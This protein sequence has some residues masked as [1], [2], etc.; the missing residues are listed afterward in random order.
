MTTTQPILRLVVAYAQNRCI[1]KDN[2]LPWH[3]PKDL[4]HFKALTLGHPIIMGRHTWESI[5]RPLPGRLNIVISRN[6]DFE[7]PGA[8]VCHS[9]AQALQHTA[10]QP[11]VCVIGGAQIYQQA[12][13]MAHEIYAT[14]VKQVVAGDAFFPALDQQWQETKRQPQPTE[15]G[16]A[17]DFVRYE[18]RGNRH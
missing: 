15:N 7:A 2:Q 4:A 13:P 6:P 16:F 18:H 17:Y 1:G 3:L 9:L 14:E 12:L 8:T 5:G 11:V 10:D